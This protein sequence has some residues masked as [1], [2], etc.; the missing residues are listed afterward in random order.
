[1]KFEPVLTDR[2]FKLGEGPHYDA[3]ARRLYWVDIIAGEAWSLDPASGETQVWRFGQPVSAVVP[4]ATGG[5]LVALAHGLV[6]LDPETGRHTDF[7]APEGD[8]PGNRSN[9]ARVD[10]QGRFWLGTMQNNIGSAGRTCPSRAR[11]ARSIA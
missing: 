3:A 11:K 1:M 7:V 8:V 6:F 4:R 5:L 9:E 2:R 10:P